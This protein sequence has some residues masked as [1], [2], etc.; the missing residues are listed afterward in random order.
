MR[1][2]E[3]RNVTAQDL[4]AIVTIDGPAAS[5][6]SSLGAALAAR[7][8]YLLFDTGVT[9]RAFTAVA[10]ERGVPAAEPAA[11]EELA[12][13]LHVEIS[14]TEETRIMIDG[15]D[16]TGRL[17]DPDV[18][19]NVS[20]YS[21]IP[22]VRKVMVAKQR[23]I[24][25]KGRAVVVGRDIGTVVLADAPV[26]LYLEAS[27]EARARRRSSQAREW[28]TT[29]DEHGARQDILGRDAIDS[30]RQTSPL[31]PAEDAVIIDT[32]D[33]TPE[34][35]LERAWEAIQCARD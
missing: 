9:Y 21:A 15:M 32:T 18:E 1:G 28:G 7:L 11:C 30:S 22:G 35:V 33:L 3:E 10:L 14:G 20:A 12:L 31:R 26:K 29:Q 24:A 19:A 8:G 27:A 13:S 16:M 17:R 4:P 34:E 2:A 5:G 25:E 6:K 23:A